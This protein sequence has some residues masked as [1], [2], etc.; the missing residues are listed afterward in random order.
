[1]RWVNIS[2]PIEDAGYSDKHQIRRFC[3]Y[4]LKDFQTEVRKILSL[5]DVKHATTSLESS[6][7][8]RIN[9]VMQTVEV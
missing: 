1:V 6:G 3:G 4:T 9:Y 8:V 5:R 7:G 2:T